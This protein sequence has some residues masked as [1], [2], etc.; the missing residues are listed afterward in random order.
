MQ[1][2]VDCTGSIIEKFSE[3][4]SLWFKVGVIEG[5]M[6]DGWCVCV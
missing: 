4:D 6:E 2:H 1:G 5:G 3:G